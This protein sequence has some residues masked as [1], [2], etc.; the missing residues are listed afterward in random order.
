MQATKQ[1]FKKGEAKLGLTSHTNTIWLTPSAAATVL[2]PA[3]ALVVDFDPS[4]VAGIDSLPAAHSRAVQEALKAAKG[5]GS[6]SK[7]SITR[8]DKTVKET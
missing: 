5:K 8:S 1:A 4:V 2:A 6:V 7:A 3:L